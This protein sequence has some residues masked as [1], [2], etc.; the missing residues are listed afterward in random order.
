MLGCRHYL[1]AAQFLTYQP[2]ENYPLLALGGFQEE[3][4]AFK[5]SLRPSR[6]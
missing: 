1:G 3:M 6:Q 4:G 5:G 2:P